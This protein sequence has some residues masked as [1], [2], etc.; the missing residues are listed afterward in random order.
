M[1]FYP[2]DSLSHPLGGNG[3]RAVWCLMPAAMEL[4]HGSYPR[5]FLDRKCFLTVSNQLE[6]MLQKAP[7]FMCSFFLLNYLDI[8]STLFNSYVCKKRH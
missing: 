3:Q 2:S 7:N 8:E 1:Y 5:F 6:N 4:N